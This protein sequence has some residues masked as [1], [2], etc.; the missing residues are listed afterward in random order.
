MPDA[1]GA[2]DTGTPIAGNSYG[3]GQKLVTRV[4]VNTALKCGEW[5]IGKPG[6]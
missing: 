4:G 5:A 2:A 6:A 3:G 1:A